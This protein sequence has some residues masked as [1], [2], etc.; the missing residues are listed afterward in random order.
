MSEACKRRP[1]R[2]KILSVSD[3]F[4]RFLLARLHMNKLVQQHSNKAVI[5]ALKNLPEGIDDIYDDAMERI[6]QQ[7]DVDRKLAKRVLSWITYAIRPLTVKELQHAL[8]VSPNMTKMDPGAIIYEKN[9]TSVCAGLV[10]I[11]EGQ[12]IIRLA[13]E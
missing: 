3:R 8:A 1:H 5:H 2:T 9:L 6:E 4:Q 10:V 12:R 13:R 7:R 11:D